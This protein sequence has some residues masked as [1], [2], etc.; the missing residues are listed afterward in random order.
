LSI[1]KAYNII[2]IEV[3]Q[4]KGVYDMS[5]FLIGSIAIV[6]VL[7]VGVIGLIIYL[8]N[9]S[10]NQNQNNTDTSSGSDSSGGFF[11]W[12]ASDTGESDGGGGG[13]GGGGE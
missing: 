1:S 2:E 7:F 6:G 9:Q 3:F 8:A 11:L 5:I 4:S 12:G 10:G 13:D